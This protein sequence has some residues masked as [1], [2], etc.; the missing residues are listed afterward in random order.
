[1]PDRKITDLTSITGAN[2]AT[3]D[4]FVLVDVSDTTMAASGTDKKITRDE[5]N[6]ALGI[7][8]PTRQIFTT[9]GN[10]TY[11]TPSGCTAIIV[12]VVGAGGGGA[13]AAGGATNAAI[14]GGGG[15]GSY[16]TKLIASPSATYSYTVG[17]GGNG[18]ADTGAN[19]SAG[20]ASTFGTAL[21]STSGGT[22]GFA[23][24]AGTTVAGTQGGDGGDIATGGNINTV[25]ITG[26]YGI[27]FSATST[28]GGSG[29]P[30]QFAGGG[31]RVG[32]NTAGNAGTFGSGGSGGNV[33]SNATGRAGGKGGDGIIVVTEFYG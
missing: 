28:I 1:M 12:E 18:G 11:T 8:P 24:A 26:E 4:L 17:T 21:L 30:S 19:G 31:I 9:A 16:C 22:G 7:S 2:T 10:G 3:G 14:G 27:R 25:G 20:G 15:S 6:I 13:G 29:A 5:L 32:G 33:R 23:L